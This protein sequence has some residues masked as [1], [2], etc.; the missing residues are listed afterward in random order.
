MS[1]F[2]VEANYFTAGFIIERG[3]CVKAAPIIRWMIGREY[4]RIY[5][6]C[7]SKGWVIREVKK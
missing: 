6:Y 5:N 2:R 1:L 4:G 7:I 3:L